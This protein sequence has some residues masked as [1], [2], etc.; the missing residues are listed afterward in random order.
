[1]MRSFVRVTALL[2]AMS[3]LSGCIIEPPGYWHGGGWGWHH[4]WH[5]DHD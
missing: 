2:L 4:G 5:H 1:M 3:L